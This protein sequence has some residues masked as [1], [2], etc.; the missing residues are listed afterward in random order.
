[1]LRS[2]LL[3]ALAALLLAAP[4]RA[5]DVSLTG[6]TVTVAAAP[7]EA[8]R[9]TLAL[10]AGVITVTDTGAAVTAG[11][12]CA[13]AGA[14]RAT[15]AIAAA[16]GATVALGDGNDTLA[17][18]G[19]LPVT[20][21]DGDGNDSMSGG[22]ADDV[23][24]ASP[25][26]DI[27]T[28]GGGLDTIDY[29][30]R[31]AAVTLDVDGFADDGETTEADNVRPGVERVLGGSGDDR[32]TGS[33]GAD[34]L[35]GGPGVDRLAGGDGDDR[36]AGGDGDDE[37][38]GGAGADTIDYAARTAPVTVDLADGVGGEAG[39]TDLV[40]GIE[41]VTGGDG[42]D[43]LSGDT[44]WNRLEGGRGDDRLDG[45]AGRDVLDG[46]DGVDTID[47]SG[48]TRNVFV[49][50]DNRDD[51]GESGERDTVRTG[52]ERILGGAADDTLTG[53]D[54]PETLAGG[55]GRDKLD[56]NGGGDALTGGEGDDQLYG[57]GGGDSL[58]GGGGVDTLDAGSEP[59]TL[60]GGA[61]N[62]KLSGGTG[63]DGV[64]GAEGNDELYGNDGIDAIAGGEGDDN[65]SGSSGDDALDGGAGADKL[66]GDDGSDRVDGGTDSDSV[67]GGTG[68]DG[69]AGGEGSDR[70][71]GGDGADLLDG[72]TGDDELR[73]DNGA[74]R[75][76]GGD[77]NDRM[78]G[79]ND[80]DVLDGGAGAD[81]FWGEDGQDTADYGTR[82]APLILDNDNQ[83][84]D[85][86]NGEGDT[87]HD[88]VDSFI[89]GAGNDKITGSG[90][91]NDLYGEG[92]DDT[93]RGEAGIDKLAGGAGADRL[94]GGAGPDVHDGGPGRDRIDARDKL[95]EAIWC[96]PGKDRAQAD[97]ADRPDS[98]ERVANAKDSRGDAAP[99]RVRPK[100]SVAT[101]VTGVRRRVGGGRFV[102]IPGFPGESLDVRLLPD[103]RYLVRKYKVHITDGYA[104]SGHAANGE[105]PR[106]LAVD[107]VPGAGGSWSDVDRLA[108]WAEPRQNRPRAPFRWVGYNGDYNHGRGNHLHLSWRHSPT[109][110]DRPARTVYTLSLRAKASRRNTAR[111]VA[112]AHLAGRSNFTLG[113]KP[114][115]RTGLR[116]PKR[117]AGT[118]QLRPIWRGAARSFGLRWSVLASITEV[119]SGFGCNMG[120]SSAGAIGWTQFMPATWRMWGMDASGDGKADPYNGV[121][122]IYSSA[123][124]LRASGAPR[125]YRKALYAYNH[126]WWYV[127]KVLAGARQFR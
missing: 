61:G 124:Y 76:L 82:T 78:W 53:T 88:S 121:D 14:G 40:G 22:S 9:L 31:T 101:R 8:N 90:W 27:Y 114:S 113:R 100:R 17:V 117:C 79:G 19:G 104:H 36:L 102:P 28:G 112:L 99:N 123:R 86:E 64:A 92:G 18:S 54:A 15:C 106:G 77:G 34:Q 58:D 13:P 24:V 25:G 60:Y 94:V 4:A 7:G 20:A 89:G 80:P 81:E 46:G 109:A 93:L 48:R 56:G 95:R 87:L 97:K 105:H 126:A 118:A 1:M 62:D 10:S 119:E 116:S 65:L 72:G 96:G 74:D 23:F 108:R 2:L 67:S 98:C 3:A 103:I 32:L 73:A 50:L 12:G 63:D 37:L 115:V 71:G 51:D 6:G 52:A 69:V 107:I 70:L 21:T 85:G 38:T 45:R 110:R 43:Q 33:T 83:P 84:D 26:A 66:A 16:A 127:N 41:H 11:A 75:L 68:D 39:E 5:A 122:A 120:P 44:G 47:Y 35:A 30:A 111:R 49:D 29:S 125:H 91:N 59:D 55:A 57:D 42:A